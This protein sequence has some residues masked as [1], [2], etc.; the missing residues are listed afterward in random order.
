MDKY[1]KIVSCSNDRH[2]YFPLVGQVVRYEYINEKHQAVI[3]KEEMLKLIGENFIGY[4][5]PLEYQLGELV[6]IP[7]EE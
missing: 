3:S 1:L 7:N 5:Y 6:F 2:W 4:I